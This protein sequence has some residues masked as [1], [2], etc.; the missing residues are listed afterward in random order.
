MRFLCTFCVMMLMAAAVQAAPTVSPATSGTVPSADGVPIR[1]SVVGAG[2]P[3]LVL[4]HC[5]SCDSSYW[6]N[7]VDHFSAD[8]RVV[9]LDLG[10]HGESG[11]HRF[12]WTMESYG[13]DVAA[14]VEALGL[15]RIVLVG[16]SMGG[17]VIIEAARLLPGKV[18][19]LV[20]VDTLQD[21]EKMMTEE[22]LE[23]F[24]APMRQNYSTVTKA[25]VS[26][27]LFVAD[28]DSSLAE[29]IA[30]DMASAPPEIA[31]SSMSYLQRH[32]KAERLD[33]VKVPLV[34]INSDRFPTNVE[35]DSRHAVSFELM[36]MT[37]V[38]HF[39]HM[40]KPDEF[41]ALLEQALAGFTAG[42]KTE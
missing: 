26:N 29:R 37:G 2:E 24:L 39:P 17:S 12:D 1:Y 27:F 5:W 20:G 9:T 33:L 35:V 25:F 30:E 42:A 40:E 13:A 31:I 41:N 15:D 8:H 21:V 11:I 14:V 7:Q 16:H 19:G 18:I 23:A 32:P 6:T 10:G 34:C 38:G 3:T 22:Q 4:V 28:S 36:T